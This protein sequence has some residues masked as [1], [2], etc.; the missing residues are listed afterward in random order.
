MEKVKIDRIIFTSSILV[1]VAVCIPLVLFPYKSTEIVNRIFYF[2]TSQLGV[3]YIWTGIGCL[4]FLFWLSFSRHGSVVLGFENEKPRFSLYSWVSM[5]FCAGVATGILYFGTI[6]WAY[7]YTSP[8]FGLEAGSDQ[9]IEWAA[10]YGMFHWGVIGWAFYALPAVAIGYFY[11]IKKIPYMRLSTSCYGLIGSRA[12]GTLGRMIDITF[13][14][15]M[16]GSVGTSIGLGTPMISAGISRLFG[17]EGSFGLNL[18]VVCIVTIIFAITVYV[19]IEKGIKRLADVNMALAL[20]ILLFILVTGPTVFILK[21]GTNSIGIML[22]NFIH[23]GTWTDPLTESRFVED[24]TVFYWAWWIAVGPFMGIFLAEI[25]R[26]RN[27]RQVI[28]GSLFFGSFGSAVYFIIFGNYALYLEINNIVPVI[29]ILAQ[30][31]APSAI[32]AVISSLP[33]GM[34]LLFL[35]CLVSIIFMATTYNSSSYAM[36]SCASSKIKINQSPTKWHRLFWAF[37]LVLLPLS[38]MFI[39]DLDS[40]GFKSKAFE[41]LKTASLLVSLPLLIVFVIMSISLA[42]SLKDDNTKFSKKN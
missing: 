38:L 32:I 30:N 15:G 34:L 11:Y 33:F 6:E 18:I 17:I 22:Q 13:M 24:W 4:G 12:E 16:I 23:M 26:G 29:N 40:E 31:G 28:L 2:M 42:K 39:G 3:I 19:G 9:A 14:F 35:F 21:M 25:S 27:I 1:I 8:P 36:A 10:T 7:Y 41:S 5:L 20:F 37:A